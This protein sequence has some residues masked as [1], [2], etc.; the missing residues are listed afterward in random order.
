[1]AAVVAAT[2]VA[3]ATAAVATWVAVTWAV[4]ITEVGAITAATA[5]EDTI[6]A[7]AD[8][9]TAVWIRRPG[10]WWP[11]LRPRLRRTRLRRL[12]RLWIR[13]RL[14]WVRLRVWQRLRQLGILRVDPVLF[15]LLERLLVPADADGLGSLPD[16]PV[17]RARRWLPLSG[18]LQPGDRE[19]H[20]LPG[21]P[22]VRP[23]SADD[24]A[25]LD[26][27]RRVFPFVRAR[28]CRTIPTT[29]TLGFGPGV[30]ASRRCVTA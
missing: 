15:Q 13:Q 25:V 24:P 9:A 3:A 2:A 6:G 16:R 23:R 19:D 8:S 27:G 11:R 1:M 4:A 17:L 29:G 28:P 7:T 5:A 22:V 12:R 30:A 26:R 21:G 14:W 10:L 20:L 18:L